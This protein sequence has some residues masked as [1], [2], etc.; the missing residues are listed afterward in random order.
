MPPP[1][2]SRKQPPSAAPYLL[3]GSYDQ[4][5]PLPPMSPS[6][7]LPLNYSSRGPSPAPSSVYGPSAAGTVTGFAYAPGARGYQTVPVDEP[8]QAP[9]G[10][11]PT[12]Q[13]AQQR[14]ASPPP[15]QSFVSPPPP[16]A[17]QP[18]LPNLEAAIARARG[19][20]APASAL[21]PPPTHSYASSPAASNI[22]YNPTPYHHPSYNS[23]TNQDLNHPQVSISMQPTST[24]RF[25]RPPSYARA[26]SRSPTPELI[27]DH[28]DKSPRIDIESPLISSV[29]SGYG[30]GGRLEDP[31]S[32]NWRYSADGDLAGGYADDE[33]RPF[34]IFPD[35]HGKPYDPDST[36]VPSSTQ[37]FGPAPEGRVNRR[38]K[39]AQRQLKEVTLDDRNWNNFVID[40]KIP[41]RLAQCMPVKGIQEQSTTR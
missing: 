22:S 12:L 10:W 2:S 36:I 41:T 14:Y 30:N 23:V 39:H 11:Q 35:V 17:S 27:D 25:A 6:D 29:E 24:I 16:T 15:R 38:N 5:R 7:T 21:S 40:A 1:S 4:A 28:D 20:P 18:N 8:R 19:Y 3:P 31:P 9:Q 33:K 37:H 34:S 26:Y 32:T 13:S